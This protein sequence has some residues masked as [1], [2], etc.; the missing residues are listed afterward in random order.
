MSG[1]LVGWY[2]HPA[3]LRRTHNPYLVFRSNAPWIWSFV[4]GL[5][6]RNGISF[7]ELVIDG[8]AHIVVYAERVEGG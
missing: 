4:L 6:L 1:C 3:N 5:L 2:L 8:S 7:S